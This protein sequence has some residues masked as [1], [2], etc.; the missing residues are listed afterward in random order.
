L[1]LSLGFVAWRETPSL[2]AL[3]AGASPAAPQAADRVEL[4]GDTIEYDVA[5]RVSIVTG[6]PGSPAILVSGK[7]RLSGQRL[8]YSEGTG[9]VK[10][11]GDVRLEQS[12]PDQFTLTARQ[13]TA[14][15]K[16]RTARAQ[17]EVVFVSGKASAT[18]G[19]AVFQ[20]KERQLTF[21]ETPVVKMDQSEL[22]GREI[23]YSLA[24]Q[25]VV[26]RGGSRVTV[27]GVAP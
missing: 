24:D 18:A 9:L 23:V 14:D 8:E 19:L 25:R 3:A 10:V 4:S 2:R 6:T 13:L 5:R 7:L 26:A 27:Q 1:A 20:G 11:E 21:S 12:V 17:G 16:A 22:A 15:V